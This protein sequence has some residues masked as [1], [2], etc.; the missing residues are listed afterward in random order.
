MRCHS[1]S[2]LHSSFPYQFVKHSSDVRLVAIAAAGPSEESVQSLVA[3]HARRGAT[4][5]LVAK[6][7]L[8]AEAAEH[9]NLLLP[10]GRD[11]SDHI[12]GALEA[13]GA[14]Q[15][16]WQR[17]MPTEAP[18]ALPALDHATMVLSQLLLATAS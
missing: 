3:V 12:L 2:F 5:G 11:F 17:R 1:L 10:A 8:P 7:A 4:L 15:P 9:H 14:G 6:L 18:L 13:R 16:V